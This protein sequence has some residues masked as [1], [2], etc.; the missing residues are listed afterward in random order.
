MLPMLLHSFHWGSFCLVHCDGPHHLSGMNMA[1]MRWLLILTLDYS[2]FINDVDFEITFAIILLEV[3]LFFGFCCTSIDF[4]MF[5][6]LSI[7]LS[8]SGCMFAGLHNP[9]V[10][11]KLF[12]VSK[13]H[14]MAHL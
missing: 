13:E 9:S 5:K 1:A 11:A 4:L 7:A 6:Y 3:F 10:Q 14:F 8:A 2:F 12:M